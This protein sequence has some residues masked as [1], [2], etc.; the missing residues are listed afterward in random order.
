MPTYDGPPYQFT[1][2]IP[3]GTRALRQAVAER[4]SLARTEVV[5]KRERCEASPSEHCEC[6]AVDAFS[7]ERA[8]RRAI[9][10]AMVGHADELGVQSVIADRR[11]WGFGT[12]HER[13]YD[14]P[15]PHDDHTH[16]GLTRWAARFLTLEDCRRALRVPAQPP[17][18]V[19]DD[20]TITKIA[21]GVWEHFLR[22]HVDGRD[23][24]AHRVLSWAHLDANVAQS[25]ARA[26]AVDLARVVERL[27]AIEQRL[28]S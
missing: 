5:R 7:S 2:F 13:H 1:T 8:I 17:E 18:D 10:D 14:G 24:Q 27:D 15:S 28:S 26:V 4:W 19:V 6:R 9:F 12:W 21:A 23:D 20:A 25:F 22:N 3:P 16:V 11:V